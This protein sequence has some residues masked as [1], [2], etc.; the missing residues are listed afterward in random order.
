[1]RKEKTAH[2]WRL[3][4]TLTAGV[5]FAFGSLWLVQLLNRSAD[6]MQA[7]LRANEPDYIIE[8]FSAVRMGKDGKPSYIVS[9]DKLVHRPIDDASDI[10]K[11]VVRNMAEGRPPMD[12]HAARA[13]VDENNTRVTLKDNVRVDRAAS[14][15]SAAMVMTTQ[16]MTVYPDEDRMETDQPVQVVQG[17]ASMTA[18]GM[19]ANNATR[20][21]HL[22]GR[23]TLV[24]PPKAQP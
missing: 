24:M 14:G 7:D 11:P 23:G 21:V 19:R 17:G 12:I 16:A 15:K 13:R 6:D 22:Q 20:E 2:R 3:G 9:G 1:M 8:Q 4:L 5:L 18:Q 10:D